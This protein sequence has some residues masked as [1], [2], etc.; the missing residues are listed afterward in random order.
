MFPPTQQTE[1]RGG[2][3]DL[4]TLVSARVLRFD[5]S[6]VLTHI[7]T[8]SGQ[9]TSSGGSST[10]AIAGGVVGGVVAVAL[11]GVAAWFV[12][13]RRKRSAQPPAPVPEVAT[14]QYSGHP[15]FDKTPGSA[16]VEAD[17]FSPRSE[18]GST[19]WAE[20]PSA[21]PNAGG[22]HFAVELDGNSRVH[23]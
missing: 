20:L 2:L 12:L 19:Q 21:S 8:G 5:T 1:V 23:K 13:R 16:A 18:L 17:T 7:C 22:H 3:E 11:V 14:Y 4:Q 6:N 10:A 15:D 9:A